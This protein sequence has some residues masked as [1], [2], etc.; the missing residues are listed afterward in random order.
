[1]DSRQCRVNCVVW[2]GNH[3]SGH[4]RSISKMTA[5]W[6]SHCYHISPSLGPIEH[7]FFI[8]LTKQWQVLKVKVRFKRWYLT[9]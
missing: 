2:Q 3:G 9:T 4:H 6:K 8:S 1:M 5:L 7:V